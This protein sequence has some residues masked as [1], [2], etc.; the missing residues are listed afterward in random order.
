MTNIYKSIAFQGARGAYSDMACRTVY[1]ALKTVPC[2]SFDAAFEAVIDG[3]AD[4]AMIP[5]DNTIA[6]RVADVHHLMPQGDLFII[7]EHF[8]PVNHMLLGIPGTKIEDIKHIHSHIHAIPQCR[9][10][11]QKIDAQTHVHADTA[12]AAHEIAEKNDSR[13]AAIASSL[14]AEIYNLDILEKR[15]KTTSTTQHGF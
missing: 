5:V 11:L 12:G 4:L 9:N 8:Q 3:N 14:A 2:D 15:L 6:G 1:P 13:H 10:F 7:G